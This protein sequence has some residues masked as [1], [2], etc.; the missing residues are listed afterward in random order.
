MKIPYN[1]RLLL[2]I[3]FFTS[4]HGFTQVI[5][6]SDTWGEQGI[7]LVSTERSGMQ[8]N[9]SLEEFQFEE[10]IIDGASMNAIR[11]PSVFLPN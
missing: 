4:Y 8:I 10:V 5:R 7:T 2:V 9:C 3:A 11:I 6:Y 1:L